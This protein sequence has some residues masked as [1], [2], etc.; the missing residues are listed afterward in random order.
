LQNARRANQPYEFRRRG[1]STMSCCVL[2]DEQRYEVAIGWDPSGK[3]FFAQV[4]D[5]TIKGEDY[6]KIIFWSGGVDGRFYTTPD[7]LIEAIQPY[8]CKHDPEMLR[9]ELIKD[10][11]ANDERDYFLD[12]SGLHE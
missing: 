10:K 8:A 1:G 9:R 12:E 3:T 2:D 4:S 5:N 6:D 11:Q 7:E